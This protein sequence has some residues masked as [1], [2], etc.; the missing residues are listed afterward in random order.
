MTDL[1]NCYIKGS[2]SDIPNGQHFNMDSI[3]NGYIP[4]WVDERIVV[5]MTTKLKPASELTDLEAGQELTELL[6][7]CWHEIEDL[8]EKFEEIESQAD[9]DMLMH[10]DKCDGYVKHE[11][12]EHRMADFIQIIR[13]AYATSYDAI[14]PVI[15]GM[16]DGIYPNFKLMALSRALAI[17]FNP[18]S[19]DFGWIFFTR[20]TPRQLLNG[21]IE[22]LR[23]AV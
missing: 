18:V 21:V 14:I 19:E 13:F 9:L 3:V 6:G 16:D 4:P 2:S 10:C 15:Q 1:N 5:I 8:D 11:T 12:G 23:P 20:L 17:N 7:G 22:V